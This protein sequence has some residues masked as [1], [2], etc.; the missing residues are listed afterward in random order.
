MHSPIC[1]GGEDL[2]HA[3]HGQGLAAA[4]REQ[5]AVAGLQMLS[6]GADEGL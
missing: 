5:E 4:L 2:V 3:L 6:P 1:R